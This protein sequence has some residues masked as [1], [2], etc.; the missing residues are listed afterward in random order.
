[1]SDLPWYR[2][3][4][5]FQCTQCGDCCTGAP[6]Y[7]WVTS[8][9]IVALA[10]AR[11]MDPQTFEAQYVRQVGARKSLKERPNGDCVLFDN[12]TRRCTAYAARPRQC[13]TWPFWDSNLRTPADWQHTCQV[14]PGSGHGRLYTLDEIEDLRRVIRV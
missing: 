3:G 2:D 13:R 9:E 10:A 5:N 8:E 7:V 11:G 4:L 1:M 6:G 14:C 12:Q